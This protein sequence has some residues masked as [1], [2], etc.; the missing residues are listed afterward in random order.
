MIHASL[1]GDLLAVECV[2]QT[3]P[4]LEVEYAHNGERLL[5]ML[6]TQHPDYHPILAIARLAHDAMQGGKFI[7]LG[8]EEGGVQEVPDRELALRAHTTILRYV[9]PELKTVEANL[10]KDDSRVIE[11]S[12]FEEEVTPDQLPP[13]PL[14]ALSVIDMDILAEVTGDR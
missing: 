14:G 13:P 8:G 12:L 3:R 2:M 1:R 5:R 11:V 4:T 10:I 9:E 7:S 6:Q